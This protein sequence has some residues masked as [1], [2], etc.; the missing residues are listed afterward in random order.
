MTRYAAES[1]CWFGDTDQRH[2]L[3]DE[4]RLPEGMVRVGYDADTQQYTFRK[5]NELW[6][7]QPGSYY[8]GELTKIG[9]VNGGNCFN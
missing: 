2:Y 6:L 9:I 4:Y 5:G 1:C 8:G 3:E 7:G